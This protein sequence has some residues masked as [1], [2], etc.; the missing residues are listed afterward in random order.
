MKASYCN[1]I[2]KF[3]VFIPYYEKILSDPLPTAV[4]KF[5]H[6]NNSYNS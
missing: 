4:S 2:P 5:V 1:R 6:F 3:S